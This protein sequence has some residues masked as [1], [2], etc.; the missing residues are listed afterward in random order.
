MDSNELK[1]WLN[2]NNL[3]LVKMGA[4]L[5]DKAIDELCNESEIAEIDE[6]F[7]VEGKDTN[8]TITAK[9]DT[10]EPEFVVYECS[11]PVFHNEGVCHHIECAR[12]YYLFNGKFP[13][14]KPTHLIKTFLDIGDYDFTVN[15]NRATIRNFEKAKVL[16]NLIVY[17]GYSIAQ[18]KKYF[19]LDIPGGKMFYAIVTAIRQNGRLQYDTIR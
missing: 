3:M 4:V 7:E 11:C 10:S 5:T 2:E 14:I 13:E 15:F 9:G 1:D 16:Y 6:T 8:Y 17:S 12:L 18:L 19:S